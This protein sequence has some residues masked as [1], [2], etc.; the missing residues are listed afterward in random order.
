MKS[1]LLRLLSI[2]VLLTSSAAFASVT[3][4]K[5]LAPLMAPVR[6]L[7]NSAFVGTTEPQEL[8]LLNSG[9]ASF[10]KRLQMIESAKE[11][12][13]VE[14]YIYK[15]DLAGR[16]FTQALIKKAQEGVKVRVI[17][18]SAPFV[19]EINQYYAA[20]LAKYGIEARFYNDSVVWNLVRVHQRSHRKLLVIDGKEAITG[21]RNIGNDYFDMSDKYNFIDRDVVV[22]G[23]LVQAMRQSFEE[24]WKVDISENFEQ[25]HKPEIH[26]YGFKDER[27]ARNNSTRSEVDRQMYR[28]YRQDL[29]QFIKG[30]EKADQFI[31]LNAEDSATLEQ[32]H[33]LGKE[34]LALSPTGICPQTYFIADL[35]GWH[36][37]A[38]VLYDH[39][40]KFIRRTENNILI[41]TPYFIMTEKENLFS[42]AL[43]KDVKVGVLT[44]SL[45]AADH[46]TTAAAFN[47]RI[48]QLL[49]QGARAWVYDGVKPKNV[50]MP[51]SQNAKWGI[52]AKSIAIDDDT[53]MI[54]TFNIDPRSKDLNSEMA[55]ICVGNKEL[56]KA[57]RD[58][59]V[60]LQENLV[61]LGPDGSPKDGR[62]RYFN[63]SAGKKFMFH[64][65]SPLANLFDF[66]L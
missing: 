5:V 54:S 31:T 56:N 22:K 18:D 9:I 25:V 14:F 48:H 4:P 53:V 16:L 66:W 64:L 33:E 23:S 37:D 41:Q 51:Q 39:L 63:T 7:P 38:R 28:K 43:K 10:E 2:A 57:L 27:E 36:K 45:S 62:G 17:V 21:G 12:I 55:I 15:S 58:D 50:K 52:H 19:R 34:Q 13:E 20:A 44:N 40:A 60:S 46:L 59:M 29:T 61:E 6:P 3:K 65:V 32:I 11:T 42:E 30:M 26:E 8:T 1:S 24:F 47:A 35:P 49:E